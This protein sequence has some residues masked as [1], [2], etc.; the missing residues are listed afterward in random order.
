MKAPIQRKG[1]AYTIAKAD[2]DAVVFDLDGVVTDTATVHAEAWKRMFDEFLEEY[3]VRNGIPFTPFDRDADYRLYI[4]GRPRID[5]V[6][7]FLRSRDIRLPEGA[8]GDAPGKESVHA[9]GNLKNRYFREQLERQGVRAYGSTV[10]LIHAL[11]RQGIKTAVISSSKNAAPVLEAAGL[12]GLFDVK[13][14]GIDAERLG[15]EGKPAPDI[16]LEACRQL[17]A[18]PGRTAVVE[19][20]LAGVRAGRAGGFK[21]VI[22]VARKGDRDAL[23]GNGADIAVED[24]SEVGAEDAGEREFLPSA[25]DSVSEIAQKAAG[26]RL[27]VFLDYDGTLTPIVETPDRAVMT[28]DMRQ[29]ITR[30]AQYCTVGIISGRD[31]GDVR[32]KVAVGSA[33][34]AGS[35]GFDISGPGGTMEGPAGIE[36][37]LPVLDEAEEE[38]SRGL[39]AVRGALV[40]RKRFAI[41]VHYRRVAPEEVR[42]VEE[43]VDRVASGYPQLRKTYGKKVFELRP[44]IDWDKGKALLS[45]LRTLGLGS[46]G[47]LPVYIGDDVTDEDA[48]RELRG[49]GLGIVV[50]DEPFET[51]AAYSLKDPGEVRELL[52]ALIPLCKGG[53]DEQLDADV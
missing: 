20:A 10:A 52:R 1:A 8:P 3:A 50:R 5:G 26:K 28:E 51:A 46:E 12:A 14:D 27:A 6:R 30:L 45:L 16:L 4:D 31:L 35:H 24:L 19:D 23:L 48:F 38:L 11:K 34:Y 13:V 47:V 42:T 37:F 44:S 29:V 49:R 36:E 22:G 41:A 33:V 40:E 7:S 9:L 15:I 32:D 39:G 2:F 43:V 21:L 18:E 17:G 53:R 25:L